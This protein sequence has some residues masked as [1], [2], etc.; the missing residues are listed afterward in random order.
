MS[1]F[2]EQEVFLSMPKFKLE[3]EKTLNNPLQSLGMGIAFAPGA[4]DFS[5]M[6]DLEALG[7][8]LVYRRSAP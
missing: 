7:K 3:Y 4:A 1:Q 6:A 2:R 8:K 5:R